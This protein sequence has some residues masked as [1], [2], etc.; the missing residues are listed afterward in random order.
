MTYSCTSLILT[1]IGHP[2][3][4]GRRNL[5]PILPGVQE[6]VQDVKSI[7]D[8][9]PATRKVTTE[10]QNTHYMHIHTHNIQRYT[11]PTA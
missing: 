11:R 3:A 8:N 1:F 5:A 4:C 7:L 2:N 6:R 10:I 9:V